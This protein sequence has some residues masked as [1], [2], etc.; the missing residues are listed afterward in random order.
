M[1]KC[2]VFVYGTLRK[3]EILHWYMEG[4]RF[5]GVATLVEY[6]LYASPHLAFPFIFRDLSRKV[7]GEVYEFEDR[8]ILKLLDR[9]EGVESPNGFY[10]R[11]LKEVVF[12]N[13]KKVKAYV[14]LSYYNKVPYELKCDLM[15]ITKGD[16]KN[17]CFIKTEGGRIRCVEL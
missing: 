12:G 15:T 17:V 13:S 9:V 1:T 6:R 10:K 8:D 7:I 3:G 11:E 2:K 5:L 16:W 4:G 14:Y